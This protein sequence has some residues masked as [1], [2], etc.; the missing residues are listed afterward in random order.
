MI[1]PSME[2]PRHRGRGRVDVE[3]SAIMLPG[4]SRSRG[5]IAVDVV[6]RCE[7]A[8]QKLE[9]RSDATRRAEVTRWAGERVAQRAVYAIEPVRQK[10][11]DVCD[12]DRVTLVPVAQAEFALAGVDHV[13]R[14]RVKVIDLRIAS[15]LINLR[16]VVVAVTVAIG[17]NLEDIGESRTGCAP[18]IGL[19][20]QHRVADDIGAKRRTRLHTDD[21]RLH[22]GGF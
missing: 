17:R 19:P 20:A 5:R 14:V 9:N 16:P 3:A 15:R 21:A 8:L 11:E 1:G 13:V 6:Q 12:L 4:R 22:H 2:R 7:P 18:V 10:V